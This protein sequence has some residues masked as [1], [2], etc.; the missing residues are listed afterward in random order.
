MRPRRTA[1]CPMGGVARSAPPEWGSVTRPPYPWTIR[2]APEE[3]SAPLLSCDSFL[4]ARLHALLV[5]LVGRRGPPGRG[6][7]LYQDIHRLLFFGLLD[8][9]PGVFPRAAAAQSRRGV[10][11]PAGIVAAVPLL[12]LDGVAEFRDGVVAG[13]L[14]LVE[15]GRID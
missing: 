14:D 1:S 12:V 2:P 6:L 3:D 5:V 4:D 9:D 7:R 11:H 8:D 15:G 13:P 10:D